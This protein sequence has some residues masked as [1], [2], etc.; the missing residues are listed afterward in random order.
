MIWYPS[1]C[2]K[3]GSS[4]IGSPII[5]TGESPIVLVPLNM[6]NTGLEDIVGTMIVAVAVAIEVKVSNK[7]RAAFTCNLL[8]PPLWFFRQKVAVYVSLYKN[9]YPYLAIYQ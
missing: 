2:T 3:A 4:S 6:G 5:F 7:R 1:Q 9:I 8:S